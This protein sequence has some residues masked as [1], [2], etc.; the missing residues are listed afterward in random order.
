VA[1]PTA[2]NYVAYIA[3]RYMALKVVHSFH[4]KLGPLVRNGHDIVVTPSP[5]ERRIRNRPSL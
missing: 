4:G 5:V 2:L 1:E 3:R